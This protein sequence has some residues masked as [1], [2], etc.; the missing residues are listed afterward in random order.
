MAR[1]NAGEAERR[2]AGQGASLAVEG[3]PGR[4]KPTRPLFIGGARLI[5]WAAN[6]ISSQR[7][8]AGGGVWTWKAKKAR[9]Q[10]GA[11]EIRRF[12]SVGGGLYF[13][14]K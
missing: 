4:A 10:L 5:G 9:V 2:R 1:R 14:E 11:L 13:A 3:I 12:R 7:E 6:I 8:A